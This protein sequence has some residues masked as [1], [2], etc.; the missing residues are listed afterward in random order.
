MAYKTKLQPTIAQSSTEAEFMGALDFGKILLYVHS[1]LWDLGVPQH[2]A[3]VMYEDNDACTAMAMA[4]KPT[5]R[6][7]HMDIKYQ[8]IC[9]WVERD[10]LHLKRIDTSINLADL[11]TKQ[12]GT[13]LFYRHT[14]FVLGHVPPHYTTLALPTVTRTNIVNFQDP[15]PKSDDLLCGLAMIWSCVAHNPFAVRQ[16]VHT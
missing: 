8:V 2:A 3:L 9:E 12:L 13:T 16:H 10:L 14:D 11:F 6:T 1:V 4:Q 15:H 5:P 7:R